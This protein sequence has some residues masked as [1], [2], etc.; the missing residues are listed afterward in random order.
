MNVTFVFQSL[1]LQVGGVPVWLGS[2]HGI[3]LLNI[4]LIFKTFFFLFRSS[5]IRN[6]SSALNGDIA[7]ANQF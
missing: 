2:Q 7:G 4:S 1:I 3:G 5:E 6:C